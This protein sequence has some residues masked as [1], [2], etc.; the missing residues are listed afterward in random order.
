MKTFSFTLLAVMILTSAADATTSRI[1][2]LGGGGDYF[3][4]DAN[5]LRWYGSLVDYPDQVFVESGNFNLSSGYWQSPSEKISGPGL[6]VHAA[7]GTKG[8]WGTVG[9]FYHDQD[10]DRDPFLLQEHLRQNFSL[11][12]A[13]SFGRITAGAIFRRGTR[14][15]QTE[16]FSVDYS[17][18]TYGLGVRVNL[19][20]NA[21]LDLAL[22]SR[23]TNLKDSSYPDFMTTNSDQENN[24]NFR[25]RVFYALSS[26]MAAVPLF[27]YATEDRLT[28]FALPLRVDNTLWRFGC[29]LNYYPDTDHMFLL[30]IDYLDGDQ[31]HNLYDSRSFSQMKTWNFRTGFESRV[32]SW[33]TTRG[34]LGI[35]H[36]DVNKGTHSPPD[37][38]Y[39]VST[40]GPELRVSLGFALHLGPADLDLGFG[41]HYPERFYSGPPVEPGKS[42][43]SATARIVF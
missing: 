34:G 12:Y 13:A 16:T 41:E 17:A 14:D 9:L 42:W 38:G 15:V 11:L 5:V 18:N 39:S 35:V 43:M 25:G 33:L 29:G 27:E 28:P 6:G 3:E 32:L 20:K 37:Y 4:D 26:T 30:S 7:L 24:T 31:N 2:S 36:Y 1:N 21:Y 40:D 19:S 23:K 8:R 10:D 22:E